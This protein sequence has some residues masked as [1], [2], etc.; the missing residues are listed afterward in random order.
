M[1]WADT[2]DLTAE[3]EHRGKELLD[4]FALDGRRAPFGMSRGERQK[5]RNPFTA[6]RPVF[7]VLSATI[8]S[9]LTFLPK[10]PIINI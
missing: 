7:S 10:M 8:V 3:K 4:L 6:F 1:P 5:A 2:E 9:Y